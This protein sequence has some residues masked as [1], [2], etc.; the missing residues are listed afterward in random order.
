MS[1]CLLRSSEG[2]KRPLDVLFAD[3]CATRAKFHPLPCSC[4][5]PYGTCSCVDVHAGR[6]PLLLSRLALECSSRSLTQ[7]SSSHSSRLSCEY[8][9]SSRSPVSILTLFCSL[10]ASAR[11]AQIPS[12]RATG[13]RLWRISSRKCE[14]SIQIPSQSCRSEQVS[15]TVHVDVMSVPALATRY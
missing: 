12:T 6:Y 13:P 5:H 3:S 8:S 10:T 11:M 2:L 4:F 14:E 1:Q 9:H 7:V 15:I